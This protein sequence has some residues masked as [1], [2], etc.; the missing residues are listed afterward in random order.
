[1]LALPCAVPPLGKAIPSTLSYLRARPPAVPSIPSNP[2]ATI[3]IRSRALN[4]ARHFSRRSGC[5]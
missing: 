2:E 4:I 1:V 5:L 3:A